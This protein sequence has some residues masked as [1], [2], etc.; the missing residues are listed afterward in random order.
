MIRQGQEVY[1]RPEWR[2]KGD[3]ESI[4]IAVEDEDGGRVK[5]KTFIPEYQIQPVSVIETSMLIE[6]DL[7]AY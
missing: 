4:W 7:I 1:V 5:V 6:G 3:E 2:D